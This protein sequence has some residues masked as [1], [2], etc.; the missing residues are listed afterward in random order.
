MML[1]ARYQAV[2]TLRFSAGARESNSSGVGMRLAT[3]LL[4]VGAAATKPARRA[5]RPKVRVE[6]RIFGGWSVDLGV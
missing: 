5:V 1:V 3:S 2:Y 4:A 6:K